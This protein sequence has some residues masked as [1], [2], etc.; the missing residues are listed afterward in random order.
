M[1]SPSAEGFLRHVDAMEADAAKAKLEAMR[2]A[3]YATPV[4][5]SAR[6]ELFH[7]DE[8]SAD[9]ELFHSE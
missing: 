9:P 6:R 8:S 3:A 2:E 1:T 5:P 4:K 7:G